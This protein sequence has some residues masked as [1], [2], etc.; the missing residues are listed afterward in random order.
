V[1]YVCS[2]SDVSVIVCTDMVN[3]YNRAS[4]RIKCPTV[5]LTNAC[6]D[7]SRPFADVETRQCTLARFELVSNGNDL[8]NK[9]W[10]FWHLEAYEQRESVQ[11]LQ[12]DNHSRLGFQTGTT[13]ERN[14][15]FI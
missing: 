11:K 15:L 2:L 12:L 9:E 5:H 13:V 10:K 1:I 8:F 3:V 14:L 7:R 6:E 4:R